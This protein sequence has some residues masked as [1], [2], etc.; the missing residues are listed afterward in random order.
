MVQSQNE[1]GRKERTGKE[2]PGLEDI[3]LNKIKESSNE[4]EQENF[5]EQAGNCNT[6]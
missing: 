4:E 6:T 3:T 5:I 1:S 2:I